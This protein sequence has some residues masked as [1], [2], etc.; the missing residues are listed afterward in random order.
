M[1]RTRTRQ[2]RCQQC[3]RQRHWCL[4][5]CAVQRALLEA[6]GALECAH[7][8]PCLWWCSVVQ[9]ATVYEDCTRSKHSSGALLAIR[10]DPCRSIPVHSCVVRARLHPS[11]CAPPLPLNPSASRYASAP[12]CHADTSH[13]SARTSLFASR[14]V[15]FRSLHFVCSALL[16]WLSRVT[17]TIALCCERRARLCD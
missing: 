1:S 11:V 3:Q 14:S 2:C 8:S 6:Q 9:C 13:S 4:S 10:S 15:P 12:L 5:V 17:H 7:V 16:A